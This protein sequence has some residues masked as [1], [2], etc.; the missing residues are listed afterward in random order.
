MTNIH[1][2]VIINQVGGALRGVPAEGGSVRLSSFAAKAGARGRLPP[3]YAIML[4]YFNIIKENEAI[5]GTVY[6]HKMRSGRL[7]T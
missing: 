7:Y 5:Y 1:H 6:Q 3:P 2:F 4:K